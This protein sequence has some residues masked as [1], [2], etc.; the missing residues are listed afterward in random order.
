MK[1]IQRKPFWLMVIVLSFALIATA[2]ALT[3]Q[4]QEEGMTPISDHGDQ[5]AEWEGSGHGNTYS[6]GKGPNTYCSR[7]HSP[8]NWDPEAFRGPP[9]D[10]FT[11]K[12]PTDEELRIAPG[13]PL[14]LE[15]DWV[16][17]GCD[18]CHMVDGDM[19]DA[20]SNA[21]YNPIRAEYE[22]VASSTE[23]CRKCHVTT[24]G[25]SF[26][27]AVDHEIY[28]GGSAHLN[29]VGFTGETPPPTFCTDCHN[30]HTQQ[31][32]G[33][34]D[35]H[36]GAAD[37]EDHNDTHLAVVS[38][39]ACH[40]ADGSEVGPHPDEEMGGVWTT[41]LN[42][43]SRGGEMTT[44]AIVSHSVQWDVSCDRCHYEGNA[45]ELPVLDA[46]GNEPEADD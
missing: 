6:E 19:I 13:N 18:T 31:P 38:C 25:N 1:I 14:V 29:Y 4:A 37:Y 16:G 8:Q 30:P 44:S 21:W 12:F 9:P 15:E 34:V 20:T 23:L 3:V 42:E 5:V 11:C 17:I 28:L 2:L 24:S 22:E 36:E 39:I 10:C 26:G 43:M 32:M 27:S 33:C 40:D 7:C 45:W 35:C 41:V 46:D